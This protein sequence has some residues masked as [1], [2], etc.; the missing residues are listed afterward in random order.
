VVLDKRKF[1]VYSAE[2]DWGWNFLSVGRRA[3]LSTD[4]GRTWNVKNEVIVRDDAPN[5]DLGYPASVELYPNT[6]LTVYYQIDRPE[7][8]LCL[9]GTI[10]NGD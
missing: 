6:I 8:T 10:W 5:G 3:C 7:E 4:Q 9:M 1:R 2:V